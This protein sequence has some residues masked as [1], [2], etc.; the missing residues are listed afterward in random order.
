MLSQQGNIEQK[1]FTDILFPELIE[2]LKPD[3]ERNEMEWLAGHNKIYPT[4]MAQRALQI[5]QSPLT[6]GLQYMMRV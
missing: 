6:F 5:K 1:Y 3:T 4:L 2:L